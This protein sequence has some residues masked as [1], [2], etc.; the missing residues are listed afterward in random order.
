[1]NTNDNKCLFLECP[2]QKKTM[3]ERSIDTVGESDGDPPKLKA[4]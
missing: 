2:K 4:I 3:T 1:M